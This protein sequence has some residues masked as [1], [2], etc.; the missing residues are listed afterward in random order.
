VSRGHAGSLT[1]SG[2][3]IA[4]AT[5]LS[6]APHLGRG[7][8]GC[9]RPRSFFHAPPMRDA[10]AGAGRGVPGPLAGTR[11]GATP[12]AWRQ[13]ARDSGRNRV[14]LRPEAQVS[15]SSAR[16]GTCCGWLVWE[17]RSSRGR[18]AA[19]RCSLRAVTSKTASGHP[20]HRRDPLGGRPSLS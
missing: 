7:M 14:A 15:G 6:Q 8:I 10:G 5:V 4:N 11:P 1:A 3:L 17:E 19:P 9:R 12:P 18:F 2:C 16:L 20:M 13:V